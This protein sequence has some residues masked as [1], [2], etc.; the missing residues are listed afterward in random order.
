MFQT[1]YTKYA[2]RQTWK[3]DVANI[4]QKLAQCEVTP[5][6]SGQKNDII[7]YY[8]RLLGKKVPV[9]WHEY[10]YSRNETF[11]VTYIII[12]ILSIGS[13]TSIYDMHT[14]TKGFM[15]P[16]FRMC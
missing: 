3:Q 10:F 9:Y 14:L 16:I 13:T 7:S 6:S 12:Q 1:L 11:S 15:M 4:R 2:I 5:L 8:E